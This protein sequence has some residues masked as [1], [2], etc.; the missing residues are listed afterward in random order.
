MLYA[1]V[2][3]TEE[4]TIGSR[5]PLTTTKPLSRLAST[6]HKRSTATLS[7]ARCGKDGHHSQIRLSSKVVT[8]RT[9]TNGTPTPNSARSR[10]RNPAS[11]PLRAWMRQSPALNALPKPFPDHSHPRTSNMADPFLPRQL[12]M[13]PSTLHQAR[14]Y[15]PT[16]PHLPQPPQSTASALTTPTPTPPPQPPAQD[17]TLDPPPPFP[18][19]LPQK[20]TYHPPPPNS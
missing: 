1:R 4:A 15:P 6:L 12:K 5:S 19:L 10:L 7:S 9:S 2:E 18:K 11:M 16:P 14:P 17:S 8:L 20:T 3:S 13:T